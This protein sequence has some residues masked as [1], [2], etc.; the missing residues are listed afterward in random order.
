MEFRAPQIYDSDGGKNCA[1][2][3]ATPICR[4]ELRLRH[5]RHRDFRA[6]QGGRSRFGVVRG[7]SPAASVVMAARGS[8]AKFPS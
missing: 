1:H 8:P 4:H 7:N 2:P 5:L 3:A 6:N